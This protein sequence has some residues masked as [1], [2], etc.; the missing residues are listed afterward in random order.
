MRG[1]LME[2][3]RLMEGRL[4]EVRLYYLLHEIYILFIR[5]THVSLH[6]LLDLLKN[7]KKS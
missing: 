6:E 4:I 7:K 1:R 5:Y 2:D 3:G